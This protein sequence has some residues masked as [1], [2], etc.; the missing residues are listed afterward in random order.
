MTNDSHR[1]VSSEAALRGQKNQKAP[2]QDE[3]WC[4]HKCFGVTVTKAVTRRYPLAPLR[5]TGSDPGALLCAGQT[6]VGGGDDVP[7]L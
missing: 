5:E 1:C 7:L 2:M 6:R 4:F 3:G